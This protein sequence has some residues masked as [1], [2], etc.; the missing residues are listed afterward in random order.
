MKDD[1]DL[2]DYALRVNDGIL[3]RTRAEERLMADDTDQDM[4]ARMGVES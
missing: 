1:S 4:T 2:E 3:P